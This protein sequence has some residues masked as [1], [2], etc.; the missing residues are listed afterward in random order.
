MEESFRIPH[1]AL[2]KAEQLFTNN[3]LPLLVSPTNGEVD[4]VPWAKDN[5]DAIERRLAKHGGLLFRGFDVKTPAKFEEFIKAICGEL[6]AYNER[7][8]PRT[9]IS[10]NIY[11]STDYPSDYSIFLHNENSYQNKWPLKIFFFCRRPAEEGGETPIADCRRVFQRIAP[12]IKER[13]IEKGWMYMR[14]FGDGFGLGWQTVF[15]T[16]DRSAVEEHCRKNGIEVEW[17]PG[18]RLRTRAVRPAVRKH[19]KTG[20]DV[21]FNHAAFFHVSSMEPSIREYLL[22]EFAE[23]DLPTN[24]FY[25]DGSTIEPSVV[26]RLRAAYLEEMV[27]FPWQSGDILLLDNML[28]A[29]GRNPYLGPRDILV[30]MAEQG[31]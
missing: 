24:T 21:W 5:S 10:G 11:S 25:G 18:G 17:K 27:V 1:Q 2:V 28:A 3:T 12:D 14:N 13:F 7:S 8:S 9:R 22:A 16:D 15:Q 26:E 23:E 29:H 4:L 19:P 6:L 20:E 31:M 30:G